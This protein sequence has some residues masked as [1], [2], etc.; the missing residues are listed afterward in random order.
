MTIVVTVKI[1]DGIVLASDSATTFSDQQG[2]VVKIYNN[3]NKAFN[4]VKGLS[5]GGLT[6]G[7]GGIGSASISTITKDLRR[8]LAG[9]DLEHDD[10]KLDPG[11]YSIEAVAQRARQFIFDELFKGAYGDDPPA[12]YFLGYKVCGYSANAPLPELWDFRI[13]GGNC[14]P[15]RLIRG[16]DDYGPNWDGEYEALDRLLLVAGFNQFERIE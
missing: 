13:V 8:R 10:W 1:N 12:E 7:A 11:N 9:D 15:P 16:Q 5:I 4:L 2:T 6:W 3:A 14:E